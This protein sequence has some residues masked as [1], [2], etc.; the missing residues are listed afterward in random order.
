MLSVL[1]VVFAGL[2]SVGPVYVTP[3]PP[4]VPLWCPLCG[5]YRIDML[6]G[7]ARDMQICAQ[8]IG[9]SPRGIE[10]AF[11]HEM[12]H[13]RSAL[14]A[15]EVLRRHVTVERGHGAGVPDI[16]GEH[17]ICKR[18][19]R[20]GGLDLRGHRARAPLSIPGVVF[21]SSRQH[22]WSSSRPPGR[23]NNGEDG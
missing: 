13:M 20:G 10:N 11:W 4:G 6:G 15:Q 3:A 19:G 2:L 22:L 12:R 18:R 14:L 8:G 7:I 23:G 5:A 1:F 21:G 9:E 16:L 17:S